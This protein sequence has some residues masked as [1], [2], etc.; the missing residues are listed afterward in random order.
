[1]AAEAAVAKFQVGF[2]VF[3]KDFDRLAHEG[4]SEVC[5]PPLRHLFRAV[6]GLAGKLWNILAEGRDDTGAGR[7]HST[8]RKQLN[9]LREVRAEGGHVRIDARGLK[10][11]AITF[12]NQFVSA[13]VQSRE[14]EAP[15]EIGESFVDLSAVEFERDLDRIVGLRATRRDGSAV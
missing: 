11:C 6:Q 5:F 15:A 13:F 4:Q 7:R 9:V 1:M 14:G 3:G 2:K 10:G 12:S 8:F